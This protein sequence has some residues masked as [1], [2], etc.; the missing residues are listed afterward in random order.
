MTDKLKTWIR[1]HED[2]INSENP[3]K[4]NQG[5]PYSKIVCLDGTIEYLEVHRN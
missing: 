1:D 5:M 4:W 3:S 2:L